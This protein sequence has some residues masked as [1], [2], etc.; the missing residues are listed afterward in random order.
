MN[1]LGLRHPFFNPAW[2]RVATVL[3]IFGWGV[4]EWVMGNPGWAAGCAALGTV[5]GWTFF[6]DWQDV[7]REGKE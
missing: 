4:F 6:F 3:A 1:L 5:S 7:P 2:R